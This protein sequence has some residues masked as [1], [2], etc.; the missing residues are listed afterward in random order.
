MN[1]PW[2]Y[3]FGRN[4]SSFESCTS[5]EIPHMAIYI[6]AKKTDHSPFGWVQSG[7][8]CTFTLFP[9]FKSE[10]LSHFPLLFS[11]QESSVP[12]RSLSWWAKMRSENLSSPGALAIKLIRVGVQD[13]SHCFFI[14]G[15]W[16]PWTKCFQFYLR[17]YFPPAPE[18]VCYIHG[19]FVFA[20][21]NNI[22]VIINWT[23][24]LSFVNNKASLLDFYYKFL[25]LCL[26]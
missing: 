8:Q 4:L 21:Y 10:R 1:F 20:I 25:F 2:F 9:L 16:A 26:A 22:S 14:P 18:N 12:L 3:A 13:E 7:S 24:F 11:W 23:P 17:G 15:L 6:L 5:P 19:L